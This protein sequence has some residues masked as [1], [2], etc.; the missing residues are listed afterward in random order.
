MLI[1]SRKRRER[2]CIRD[3]VVVT[4]LEV[5][6]NRVRLGIDAPS[7]TPVHRQEV[8]ARIDSTPATASSHQAATSQPSRSRR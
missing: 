4:V 1:L 8:R 3:D 2:I 5:R 6:G 7:G